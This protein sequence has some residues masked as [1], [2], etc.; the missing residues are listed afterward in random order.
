MT[1]WLKELYA[2]VPKEQDW[3]VGRW[4]NGVRLFLIGHE[5]GSTW[6]T[7]KAQASLH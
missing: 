2:A 6:L 1:E 7:H 5:C 3:G 4:G